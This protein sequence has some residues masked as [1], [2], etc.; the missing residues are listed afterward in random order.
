MNALH[1]PPLVGVS[2]DTNERDRNSGK[3][4]SALVATRP[5][6]NN[7]IKINERARGHN[8][9]TRLDVERQRQKGKEGKMAMRPSLSKSKGKGKEK[10][11]EGYLQ[12]HLPSA[13][14][15]FN[16]VLYGDMVQ[17]GFAHLYG[18]TPLVPSLTATVL[19]SLFSPQ[20]LIKIH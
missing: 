17:K 13:K 1:V 3:P 11:D 19:L 8:K 15:A 5:R 2:V 6:N 16:A 10:D 12:V 9:L 20:S 7:K 4:N 18:G 14:R